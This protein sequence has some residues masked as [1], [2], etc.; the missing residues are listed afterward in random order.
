MV[1]EHNV[2]AEIRRTVGTSAPGYV[3]WAS[4]KMICIFGVVPLS[5]VTGR[6]MPWLLGTD[7]MERHPGAVMRISSRYIRGMAATFSHLSNHV[8]ARNTRSVKWLRRLGFTVHEP[9]PF[10]PYGAPFHR[11]EMGA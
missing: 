1:G 3:A 4:D 11:F 9:E 7:E 5:I 8:D 10:G 6:G 2:E